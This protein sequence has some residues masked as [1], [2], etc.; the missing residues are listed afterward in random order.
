M[1]SQRTTLVYVRALQNDFGGNL[2]LSQSEAKLLLL[3]T[4]CSALNEPGMAQAFFFSNGIPGFCEEQEIPQSTFYRAKRGLVNKGFVVEI[5]Q[6]LVLNKGTESERKKLHGQGLGL[7]KD[8]LRMTSRGAGRGTLRWFGK[9]GLGILKEV[10]ETLVEY[11]QLCREYRGIGQSIEP[12]EFPKW[13]PEDIGVRQRSSMT[14][15]H[16]EFLYEHHSVRLPSKSNPFATDEGWTEQGYLLSQKYQT[17]MSER[18]Y[19]EDTCNRII[20]GDQSH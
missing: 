18:K 5:P 6:S 17:E 8:H 16:L 10:E 15:E 12:P 9:P 11:N 20:D 13:T 19:W 1:A 3:L 14:K 2:G 4:M 7:N